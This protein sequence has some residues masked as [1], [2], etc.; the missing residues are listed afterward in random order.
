M[1]SI[2][3]PTFNNFDYLK[4]CLNSIKKNSKYN[5]EIILHLNDGKDGSL[6][7]AIKN[8]IKHSYSKTN[9][10]L[11]SSINLASNLSS[12]KYILYSHDD[13]YFCP[14]WDKYL[15]EEV[16][17]IGHDNFYLSGTMIEPNSGHI[18]FNCGEDVGN[19]NE[20]KLLKNIDKLNFHD[21]QGSHFAPHLVSKRMWDEVGGF[22]EEFNPGI[23][24]DP[25]FNMKLWKKGV[26]IF[27]GINNFKVYHFG[28][29]TT[30]KKENLI[31][32]RGDRTFLKK[33]GITTKFFKK[34]YLKSKTKYNGPL[35]NPKITFRF[36]IDFVGCKIRS[37]FTI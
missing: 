30:R 4:L 3:I 26:R 35:P 6:N 2:I 11:C 18:V 32:N 14:S 7:Y 15:Y 20:N 34:Y 12:N 22:S 13:M 31:Q 16:K 36:I 33:W 21:H 9:I 1:F 19:F 17:R 8:N 27:M 24:S 37:V 25:D 5:H 10:G 29:V 23:A 28:S